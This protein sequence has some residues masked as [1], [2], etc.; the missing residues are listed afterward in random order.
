MLPAAATGVP[1]TVPLEAQVAPVGALACGPK[2]LNVI[3]PVA[4]A[5]E[6]ADNV[7]PIEVERIVVPA[8]PIAGPD[9]T[10]LGEARPTVVIGIEALHALW[11]LLSNVSPLNDAYH[12]YLPGVD[13]VKLLELGLQA[14]SPL[15][16]ADPTGDHKPPLPR[17]HEPA[18]GALFDGP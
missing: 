11:A 14:P 6:L 7:A 12:Q 15:G 1:T 3:S 16:N 13:G 18:A 17:R 8:T 10:I 5:P 4:V 9:A 2:T